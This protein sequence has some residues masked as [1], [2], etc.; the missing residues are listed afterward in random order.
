MNSADA[1]GADFFTYVVA[2]EVAHAVDYESF[3]KARIKRDALAVRLR[4]ARTEA[5]R[6]TVDPNAGLGD[7][8]AMAEKTMQ[9]KAKIRQIEKDLNQAEE[10][11]AKA[12]EVLDE[13]TGGSHSRSKGFKDASK[14][15]QISKYGER[16][17]GEN[18]A[19]L[20]SI[21]ILDPK[22]LQSLRPEAF[23]YFAKTFP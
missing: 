17:V 8:K 16:D 18:F 3:T 13:T 4:D 15:K 7:D 5:K 22:L 6:V 11:F 21:Y 20:Y 2:H 19:E 10:A 23:K 14:G 9:D 12:R 1:L